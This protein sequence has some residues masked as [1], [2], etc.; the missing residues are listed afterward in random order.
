MTAPVW[1]DQQVLDQLLA[2]TYWD[3]GTILYGFPETARQAQADGGESAGFTPLNDVQRSMANLAMALWGD[4]IALPVAQSAVSHAHIRF[5][6]TTTDIEF[7]HAYFPPLGGVWFNATEPDL[8]APS[9]GNYGF[10]TYVHEIGHA[11]GLNHMGNYDAVDGSWHPFSWQDSA[12][13]SIMSYF[14]PEVGDGEGEVAWGNWHNAAGRVVGP[15]TPMIN[16]IMAIQSAYGASSAR[17][18]NT[19]YGFGANVGGDTGWLYD[20]T[21]NR[22]PVLAI[23]DSGG[24]DT[25]DLGGWGSDSYV[26][27][28]PGAFSSLNGM[29]NNVSIARNTFIEN[30]TTG[31][32]NDTVIGNAQDNLIR[33]GDGDDTLRGGAGDDILD[34]GSGVDTAQF[35]ARW[36]QYHVGFDLAAGAHRVTDLSGAEGVDTLYNIELGLF[37]DQLVE[38]NELST[39]VLRFYNPSSGSHIYVSSVDEANFIHATMPTFVYEGVAYDRALLGDN[40]V[41]VYRFFNTANNT[42]FYTADTGEASNVLAAYP[43]FM[44]EGVAFQAHAAAYDGAQAVH[45]FYNAGAQTHFYTANVDEAQMVMSELADHFQ[46]EGIAF[47]ADVFG[48]A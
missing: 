3:T 19:V 23:Y 4:L 38:M 39:S 12:V 24:I 33:T 6:Q 9:P 31:G 15:Q 18:E 22:D 43:Q 21:L 11:L 10:S 46:Y 36:Q 20:F 1:T 37:D 5:G 34:G 42:H 47:Y 35:A 16:D 45:R 44:L 17:S 28:N 7:A 14:G 2:G 8:Q 26:D 41:D 48:M 27:L 32:G 13:Y 29:T 30:A 25:L 40:L